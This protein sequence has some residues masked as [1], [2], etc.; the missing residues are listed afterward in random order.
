[1]KKLL[2]LLALPLFAVAV[3]A[4]LTSCAGGYAVSSGPGYYGPSY[5][6]TGWG[7]TGF[8]GGAGYYGGPWRDGYYDRFNSSGTAYGRRGG[9]V[10]WGG[11]SGS[12]QG[13]RGGSVSW[14]GGSG[15]W[16]GP[17]GGGGSWHR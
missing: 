14:G 10:S 4:G 12:A 15:S 8:Y 5:P 3:S 11:G 1:M 2:S 6:V 17:R 16:Q 13:W 7:G 9:S